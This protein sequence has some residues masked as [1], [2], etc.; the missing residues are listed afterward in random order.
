MESSTLE[1]SKVTCTDYHYLHAGL[2]STATWMVILKLMK[3]AN[4][5][6]EVRQCTKE[7]CYFIVHITHW[8]LDCA[9]RESNLVTGLRMRDT[10]HPR[11]Q[12]RQQQWQRQPPK[13]TT[14]THT[15]TTVLRPYIV[16]RKLCWDTT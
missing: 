7:P 12:R 15:H 11:R 3:E 16:G 9:L 8:S 5:T 10:N 2:A 6:W 4:P 1:S 14:H 13:H